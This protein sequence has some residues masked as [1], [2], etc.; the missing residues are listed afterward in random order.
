MKCDTVLQTGERRGQKCNRQATARHV[1]GFKCGMHARG[2]E[3]EIPFD[4]AIHFGRNGI[5]LSRALVDDYTELEPDPFGDHVLAQ[6]DGYINFKMGAPLLREP[7]SMVSFHPYQSDQPLTHE[8]IAKN[9]AE[10]AQYC[11]SNPD[12]FELGGPG[13]D[14]VRLLGLSYDNHTGLYRAQ[15]A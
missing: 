2:I 14:Q 3:N 6:L 10:T 5:T 15:M 9:V 7:L 13:L 4:T 1:G 8:F 12:L 11:L